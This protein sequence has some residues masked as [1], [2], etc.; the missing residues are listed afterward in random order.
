MKKIEVVES[1]V[2][3]GEIASIEKSG[4]IA[5]YDI[6]ELTRDDITKQ[7]K[8]AIKYEIALKNLLMKKASQY[9]QIA[10]DTSEEKMRQKLDLLVDIE[11]IVKTIGWYKEINWQTIWNQA[12]IGSMIGFSKYARVGEPNLKGCVKEY[13]TFNN[14]DD[15]CYVE[16][17]LFEELKKINSNYGVFYL[18]FQD[19]RKLKKKK[20]GSYKAGYYLKS[21]EYVNTQE[22]NTTK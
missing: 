11:E 6:I 5:H 22:Q 4:A 18:K 15:L 13:L 1:L 20:L 3:A 12:K 9:M 21:I 14:I 19:K 16:T 2:R 17:A 8:D 10:G 7:T